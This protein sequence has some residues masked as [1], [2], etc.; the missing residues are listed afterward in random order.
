MTEEKLK[1]A[2]IKAHNSGD[3]EAAQLFAS[4]IKQLRA[5]PPQQQQNNMIPV[6]TGAQATYADITQQPAQ[7]PDL[8]IGDR[9]V[10]GLEATAALATGATT[11]T[12][13]YGV[14]AVRGLANQAFGDFTSEQAQQLAE[15]SA[16]GLT[17]A[18]RTRAGQEAVGNIADVVGVLPPVVA[19]FTPQQLAGASQSA[20]ASA[21]ASRGLPEIIPQRQLQAVGG[22]SVGAAEVPPE[23]VRMM[24]AQ[25]LPVPLP[26]TKGM[27]SQDFAQ[28]RFER[29]IA[30]DPEIGAPI[31]ERMAVLNQGINQNIDE[32]ISETGTT[33]P[34]TSWRLDTG[35]KVIKAL[36]QGYQSEKRKV[37]NAYKAA[38]EKGETQEVIDVSPLAE[39][40]NENVVDVTVAPVVD[41]IA[42]EAVRIGV[43]QGRIDDGSFRILPMTVEQSETLRKRVNTL[44]DNTNGQD[45]RRASQIKSIIDQ[46]QEQAGGQIFKSARKQR[47]QLANKYENLAIIDQL[48][49]TKGQYSDQRIAAENV[50][51]KAVINGSVEDLKN[52]RRVLSTAG[53]EGLSAL[54]EVRAAALRHIRDEATRNLGRDPAGNPLISAKGMDNAI[55]ALDKDG[56]LNL[57]FGRQE[58]AKIRLLNDV[59]KDI[60]VAQPNAV[61]YSNT[62]SV[63]LAAL[64]MGMSSAIGI[65]APVLSGLKMIRDKAKRAKTEKQ[66]KEALQ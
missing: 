3:K 20:R 52:L 62:A 50:I 61:N 64:D 51:N 7:Q 38:R 59:A 6:G 23:Q 37:D 21:A 11:G 30:K 4:K 54:A 12:L 29:E 66:I 28:Q 41:A 60:L 10:G 42:R 39:Y 13:G 14:G 53:D 9:V 8:T 18:P 27:A 33:L 49:D 63:L 35:N 48:L 56:K 2:L 19:G 17:Y 44:T 5:A 16:A 32:F 15:Q 45:L 34:E 57:L 22:L 65:P 55:K 47:Q 40:L 46:S 25:E 43:G 58:A 26:L 24:Q 31:R 36:E 1:A